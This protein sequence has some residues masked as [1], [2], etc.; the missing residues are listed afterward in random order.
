MTRQDME[1]SRVE[2]QRDREEG[3]SWSRRHVDKLDEIAYDLDKIIV[4][5]QELVQQN[6]SI[7]ARQ[8]DIVAGQ[9]RIITGQMDMIERMDAQLEQGKAGKDN[10]QAVKGATFVT[11]SQ[12]VATKSGTSSGGRNQEEDPYGIDRRAG[13]TYQEG[14]GRDWGQKGIRLGD[15]GE[16]QGSG[17]GH[18]KKDGVRRRGGYRGVDGYVRYIRYIDPRGGLATLLDSLGLLT[19]QSG[20]RIRSSV[21]DPYSSDWCTCNFIQVF[22]V[23][24]EGGVPRRT[25]FRTAL[26]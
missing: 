20:W 9:N 3:A 5:N 15:Q 12:P 19:V 17:R 10:D 24:L 16:D 23:C 13:H 21:L 7:I 1:A 22:S 2:H 26:T 11:P 4:L 8:K 18:L 6:N 25:V 14:K